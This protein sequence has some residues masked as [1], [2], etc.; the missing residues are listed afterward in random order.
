MDKEIVKEYT[1]GELTVVWK[2]KN[3]FTQRS[4]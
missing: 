3:A 1:N 4:V 2:Q